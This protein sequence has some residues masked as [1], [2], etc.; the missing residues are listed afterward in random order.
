MIQYT[1]RSKEF[2]LLHALGFS[3]KYLQVKVF[4]EIG[5]SSLLGYI[6]GIILAIIAGWL[7]NVCVLS[8]SAMEMQ[9]LQVENILWVLFVPLLV[10]LFG[11]I[12]PLKLLKFKDIM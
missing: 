11:M 3:R 1:L 7:V 6:A 8:E 4:K 10:T 2:E 5:S 12:S 9:L